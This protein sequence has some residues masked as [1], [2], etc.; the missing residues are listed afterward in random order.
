MSDERWL[1]GVLEGNQA[2]AQYEGRVYDRRL[3]VRARNGRLLE[4]FDNEPPISGDLPVGQTF[5][6]IV[7][8]LLFTNLKVAE[9]SQGRASWRATVVAIGWQADSS[10]Y[11]AKKNDLN[12][13]RWI[14]LQTDAGRLLTT[15][16]ELGKSVQQG[17]T[18]S[19]EDASLDL[20][21]VI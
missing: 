15:D 10:L 21:A 4:I 13:R 18:V 1:A 11:R 16:A 3:K 2:G 5:E 6:F 17:E 7:M 20:Y 19:W 9:P 14:L 8:A 12:G